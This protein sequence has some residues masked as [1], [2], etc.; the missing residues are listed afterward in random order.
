[1]NIEHDICQEILAIMATYHAQE[2]SPTGVATPG[3]LAHLGDVWALFQR[4]ENR[5]LKAQP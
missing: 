4:W 2:K 1:V 5:L 3:G